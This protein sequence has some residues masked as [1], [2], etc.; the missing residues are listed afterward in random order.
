[1]NKTQ[2]QALLRANKVAYL[3]TDSVATLKQLV[4]DAN[5]STTST[6]DDEDSV[7][8]KLRPAPSPAIVNGVDKEIT[9]SDILNIRWKYNRAYTT[10]IARER[11]PDGFDA[12][13]YKKGEVMLPFITDD[14]QFIQDFKDKEIHSLVLTS[15]VT[16]DEL[17]ATAW[18]E[19]RPEVL[20]EAHTI[21]TKK[22]RA[23]YR[24]DAFQDF[25]FNPKTFISNPE[26]LSKS[27]ILE[28][29]MEE[30]V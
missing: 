29:I 5:I 9:G 16:G 4:Q 11:H 30:T 19:A 1:M 21:I 23:Y 3:P 24:S 7:P 2:L 8:I 14:K 15:V 20:Y 18:D 25:V 28:K 17:P 26:L 12:F 13:L 10:A 22:D 27:G 6:E